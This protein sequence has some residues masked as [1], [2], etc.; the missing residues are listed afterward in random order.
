MSAILEKKGYGISLFLKNAWFSIQHLF[1]VGDCDCDSIAT[2]AD[3]DDDD[4]EIH[5]AI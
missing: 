1:L 2:A 4:D 5:F 3:H